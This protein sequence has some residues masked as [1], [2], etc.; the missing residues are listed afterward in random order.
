MSG[1]RRQRIAIN[2]IFVLLVAMMFALPVAVAAQQAAGGGQGFPQGA[3]RG[4]TAPNAQRQANRIPFVDLQIREPGSNREV[5]FSVQLLLLLT[6]LSL[7]PSIL[8]LTT[9]FLRISIVLDFIKRA[10]SLQQVPPTQVLNGVALF[11]SLFI[12]WPTFTQVYDNSF[13]P[14]ADGKLDIPGAY[15]EAEK[16]I[17]MFM[18][19]QMSK[20][21][22][23]IA[24]FMS[25]GKMEKPR[26]LADVPTRVLV[27]A[28]ILHELTVA[29]KI[30]I[31]LYIPFIIVDMVVASVLMSMGMIM[32]PPVQIS[33]PFKLILFILVDGWGLLT[34]Q[35]FNSFL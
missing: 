22:S 8:I 7:A 17:R 18:Y 29:F 23:T 6:V 14:L 35:L 20:D 2:A 16:P 32:L 13:K 26:T 25:M 30:G 12:M 27:P 10:L 15:A 11:L 28:Y 34:Q 19:R 31:L 5:A 24:M 33:M 3:A 1:I 9:S 4:T 21:T